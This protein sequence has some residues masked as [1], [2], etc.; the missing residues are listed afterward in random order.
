MGEVWLEWTGPFACHAGSRAAGQR[1]PA[2]AHPLGAVLRHG[3]ALKRGRGLFAARSPSVDVRLNTTK[4][5]AANVRSPPGWTH[6]FCRITAVH[7]PSVA[8]APVPCPRYN[9]SK[10]RETEAGLCLGIARQDQPARDIA[11]RSCLPIP[12][13]LAAPPSCSRLGGRQAVVE[14][15]PTSKNIWPLG[16]RR[17]TPS[18]RAAPAHPDWRYCM[19]SS[20]QARALCSPKSPTA[21]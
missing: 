9:K 3:A 18:Q 4:Q 6:R 14:P 7:S 21:D 1:S 17:R 12:G 11:S 13:K 20:P 16:R 15:C 10:S 5:H 2:L 19:L 8:R